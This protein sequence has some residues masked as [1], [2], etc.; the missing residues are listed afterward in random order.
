MERLA[1]RKFLVLL[2]GLALVA[3]ARWTQLDTGHVVTLV[4][5]YLSVEGGADVVTRL[6]AE[7][8]TEVS[9]P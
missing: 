6:R 9:S 1:S 4:L 7:P 2:A 3:T 8:P 5:A